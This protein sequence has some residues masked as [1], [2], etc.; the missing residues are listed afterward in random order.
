LIQKQRLKSL[1]T[2]PCRCWKSD[3]VQELLSQKKA[4]EVLDI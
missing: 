2:K 1:V 3:L 4:K